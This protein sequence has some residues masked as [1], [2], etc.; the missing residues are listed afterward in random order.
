MISPMKALGDEN[1]RLK[2]MYAEMSMQAELLKELLEKS[3]AAISTPGA[4][5]QMRAFACRP[6]DGRES[7]G[8]A[9]GEHC[10]RLPHLWCQ[11]D[12]LSLQRQAERRERANRLSPDRVDAGEEE[13]RLRPLLSLACRAKR[14]PASPLGRSA[15]ADLC[16]LGR[17]LVYG[18]L[19]LSTK[20]N[21]L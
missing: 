12:L 2:K 17:D 18:V 6:R 15:H 8:V 7:G 13:P 21:L 19:A 10:T 14:R 3:D 1:R 4:L 5:R 11:R 16:L 20:E 9:R